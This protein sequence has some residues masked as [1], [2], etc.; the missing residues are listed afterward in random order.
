M[1]LA[2]WALT[3]VLSGCSSTSSPPT[4]AAQS[5]S[6]S[7]AAD[8]GSGPVSDAEISAARDAYDLRLAECIRGKGV[9]V[10]DPRPGEGIRESGPEVQAASS[11]CI[12]ELGEPPVRPLTEEDMRQI[13]EQYL[14]TAACL[15]DLGY[16]VT[17]PPKGTALALEGVSDADFVTCSTPS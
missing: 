15:R 2:V 12:S 7:S 1:V 5:D 13:D 9:E 6:P 11:S 4:V 3:L 14:K 10:K 16:D 17:D 8:V